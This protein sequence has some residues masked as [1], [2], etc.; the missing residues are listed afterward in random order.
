M[1]FMHPCCDATRFLR[2][3]KTPF[4]VGGSVRLFILRGWIPSGSKKEFE[5]SFEAVPEVELTFEQPEDVRQITP[6]VK[7]KNHKLFRP[8]EFYVKMFGVPKYNEIDPTAFVAITY[9][10]LYGIMFADFGQGI[11]LAIAGWVMSRKMKMELGRLLI[12]C[13]MAGSFFGLVFG[14]R[15]RLRARPRP[16]V[17]CRWIF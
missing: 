4:P 11:I 13:G 1:R 9:T 7:L 6:P 15:L 10:I 16:A 8:Y 5:K 3:A 14:S 12:P 2:F 17:S